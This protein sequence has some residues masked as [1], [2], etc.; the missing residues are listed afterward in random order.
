MKDKVTT[1]RDRF[2]NESSVFGTG[3]EKVSSEE[4]LDREKVEKTRVRK[5]LKRSILF[6]LAL[7]IIFFGFFAW[8]FYSTASKL[9]GEKDPI[10]LLLSIWPHSLNKSKGRVNIL[11]A[12]YSL[13]DPHHG[14]AQ[15]TDSI[16]I[17][18]INPSTK[19]ATL[20]SVPRDLWVNIPGY[21]YNKINAAYEYGQNGNFDK[22]GYFYGGMG[23]LEKIVSQDF[24]INFNYYALINYAAIKDAVNAVGGITVTISSPDPRGIYD[25]Y[26]HLKLPNGTVHLNGQQALDLARTRGDGPGA[27]G[28][29]DA[30]FTRTQYQQKELVALKD[31]ASRLS[32]LIDP[33]TVLKLM[34]SVG[35]NVIT[36]LK[37]GQMETIYSDTKGISNARIK[38]VTLNNY[39]GQDLLA[40]YY[41]D[42]LDALIP[43][44]GLNNFSAIK[45]AIQQILYG[46]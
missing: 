18:S 45:S 41:P 4:L 40:N 37:I 44:S 39:N 6:L 26:T 10:S 16:M 2:R 3:L 36:N 25:P 28:I 42:G 11:L 7:V 5:W 23:L 21:G 32:S 13:D 15:L 30:D 34:N 29:P 8:Q 22:A 35:N 14:G 38:Q 24:G 27:Y 9:T 31:K 46:S 17:I 19:S 43:A 12:G 1:K 20:I 33:L